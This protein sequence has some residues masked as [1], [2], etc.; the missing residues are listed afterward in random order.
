MADVVSLV[1]TLTGQVRNY[2]AAPA[3]LNFSGLPPGVY[4]LVNSSGSAIPVTL[5]GQTYSVPAHSR[6]RF[7]VHP[8]LESFAWEKGAPPPGK[9]RVGGITENVPTGAAS[10]DVTASRQF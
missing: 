7:S 9:Q 6:W 2:G 8:E 10:S 1:E 3:A 5:F 4:G